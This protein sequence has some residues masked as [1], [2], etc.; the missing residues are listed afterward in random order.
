[1]TGARYKKD[2]RSARRF[3]IGHGS[4]RPRIHLSPQ[5]PQLFAVFVAAPCP[6]SSL[7]IICRLAASHRP[8]SAAVSAAAKSP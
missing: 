6:I 8:R 7:L 3:S 2:A 5:I 1:M 4:A